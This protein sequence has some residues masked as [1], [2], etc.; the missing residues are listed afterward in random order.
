MS[1]L[2]NCRPENVFAIFEE[3]CAIPHG[4][5]NTKAISDYCVAFAKERG[6][7]VVQ[8]ELNNVIIRKAASAGYEHAPTVILQGHLDMVCVKEESCSKDMAQEGLDLVV[9]G[10]FVRAAGTSLGGDDG[11]AVAMALAVLDDD[12]LPHPPLEV[13]FTVDEETGMY[14][15]IGVDF[16]L[17]TGRKL[18]NI[19]SEEENVITVGCAGGLRLQADL[20]LHRESRQ[21]VSCTVTVDG[22]VGGH[23]GVEIHKG[24]AAAI[25]VL[26][27]VLQELLDAAPYALT[28][29]CG[30]TVGNAIPCTASATLVAEKDAVEALRRAC[31]AV[32]I[33]LRREYAAADPGLCVSFTAGEEVYVQAVDNAGTKAVLFALTQLPQ[34]VVSMSGDI[35][36]LVQTS[37]NLG[38]AKMEGDALM[39]KL[40]LRSNMESEKQWLCRRIV[41]LMEAAGGSVELE[42]GYPA[43]EFRRESTLRELVADCSREVFG[44]E[45]QVCAIHAGLECGLFCGKAAD[46]DCVSIGPDILDIHS[47]QERLSIASTQRVYEL[48]LQV[49]ESSRG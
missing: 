26:G 8:D 41:S 39:L 12:T 10:D 37:C 16:S 25:S 44:A 45:P 15:A 19:D 9:E 5:G 43:W 27:R 34:G 3:L 29:L 22:L 4:S 6:L 40:L 23:S 1:V 36:G 13:L 11:I 49:L 7:E 38:V 17:L 46:L 14:G 21:G 20:P 32:G 18:I 48:L 33:A 42:G 24:R 31:E 47:P 30:G 35:E 2:E 28:A